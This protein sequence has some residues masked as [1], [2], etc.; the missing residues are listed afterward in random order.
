MKTIT[1]QAWKLGTV[2]IASMLAFALLFSSSPSQVAEAA[3]GQATTCVIDIT[4]TPQQSML[5]GPA[6]VV[7]NDANHLSNSDTALVV[8][9]VTGTLAVGDYIL[10]DPAG[11]S[12]E[13]VLIAAV[14]S[15]TAV[16][17]TRGQLGTTA[18]AIQDDTVG[19]VGLPAADT[20]IVLDGG[21]QG[22]MPH[23]RFNGRTGFIQKRQGVAWIVAVKDGNMQ[24]TVIARPEHLRPLE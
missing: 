6:A 22:G 24:K 7:V 19:V 8:D 20:A 11:A 17:I 16:T 18:Y 5:N 23:R 3:V 9:G 15:Q 10:F 13:I 4:E 1:A 2:G 21:Q 14:A 12:K